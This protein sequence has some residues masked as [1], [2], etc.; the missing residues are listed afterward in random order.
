MLVLALMF[1]VLAVLFH[2]MS[3]VFES[4]LWTRPAVFTRFG[5]ASRSDADI[6]RPMAY[7]H[8]STIWGSPSA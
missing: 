6:T 7:N 4:L 8:G 1:G 5:V 2:V 3:F